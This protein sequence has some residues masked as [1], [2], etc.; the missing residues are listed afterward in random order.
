MMS[1]RTNEATE[2]V[3]IT[4][5]ESRMSE[6]LEPADLSRSILKY[7]QEELNKIISCLKK[8]GHL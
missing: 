3:P 1:S 8:I 2:P 7:N 4:H 6:V 5:I